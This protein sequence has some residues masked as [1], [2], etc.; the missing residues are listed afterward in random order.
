MVLYIDVAGTLELI[1]KVPVYASSTK[2]IKLTRN[3]DVMS[4]L[5]NRFTDVDEIC[6]WERTVKAVGLNLV[7]GL[8]NP[9]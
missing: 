4:H 7:L 5:R 9:V 2:Y 3:A 8:I 1:K 6:Y